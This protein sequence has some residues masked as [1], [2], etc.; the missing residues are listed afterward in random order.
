M[1]CAVRVRCSGDLAI[2]SPSSA[3][4]S[5]PDDTHEYSERAYEVGEASQYHTWDDIFESSKL[6][7]RTS[8]LPRFSEKTHLSFEL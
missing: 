2:L 4:A 5:A 3:G 7:D 1:M 6:K 8:L